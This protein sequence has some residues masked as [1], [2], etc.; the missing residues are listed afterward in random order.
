M[1]VDKAKYVNL[2]CAM[3]YRR[4]KIG[5]NKYIISVQI[6]LTDLRSLKRKISKLEKINF[7]VHPENKCH[8]LN[9]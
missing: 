3:H 1:Q 5:N 2:R 9:Q 4:S 8:K 6:N 7:N